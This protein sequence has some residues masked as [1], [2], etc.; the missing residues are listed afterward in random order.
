MDALVEKLTRNYNPPDRSSVR[1]LDEYVG[2]A[3]A[4][5]RPHIRSNSATL[6]PESFELQISMN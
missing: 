1:G 5:V 4:V 6:R 2:P 3:A